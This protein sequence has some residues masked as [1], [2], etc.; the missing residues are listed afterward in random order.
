[1]RTSS[2]HHPCTYSY[3]ITLHEIKAHIGVPGNEK[4]DSLAEKG[5]NDKQIGPE[6]VLYLPETSARDVLRSN[7]IT[8]RTE[9]MIATKIEPENNELLLSFPNS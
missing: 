7:M 6:T 8:A 3:K 1:M 2:K 9:K 5:A 4:A